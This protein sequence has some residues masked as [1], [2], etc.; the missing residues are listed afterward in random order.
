MNPISR[1]FNPRNAQLCLTFAVSFTPQ[2]GDSFIE[3]P[4]FLASLTLRR[5]GCP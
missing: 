2:Y 4:S 3:V 5:F 1:H